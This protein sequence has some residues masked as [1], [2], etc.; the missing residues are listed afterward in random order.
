MACLLKTSLRKLQG[1]IVRGRYMWFVGWALCGGLACSGSALAGA[2]Q[3]GW[4]VY[5]ADALEYYASR[6]PDP[7]VIYVYTAQAKLISVIDTHG[8]SDEKSMR[9]V[10]DLISGQA[11]S[12]LS[13]GQSDTLSSSFDAFMMDQGYKI[14]EIVSSK[15]KYTLLLVMP[16]VKKTD[17]ADYLEVEDRFKSAIRKSVPASAKGEALYSVAVLEIESPKEKITCTG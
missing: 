16:K 12:G 17:C 1:G 2:V 3:T 10:E 15:T 11:F 9:K 4:P 5:R 13:S 7:I 14:R 8:G 6:L